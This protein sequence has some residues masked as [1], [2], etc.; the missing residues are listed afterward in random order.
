MSIFIEYEVTMFWVDRSM[1][2]ALELFQS[3]CQNSPN[4]EVSHSIA[5]NI[6][7]WIAVDYSKLLPQTG[8][9]VSG[10]QVLTT[11]SHL[12][13]MYW[14]FLFPF[15]FPLKIT[16]LIDPGMIPEISINYPTK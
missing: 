2:I 14:Y 16:K 5:V 15:F 3:F 7:E 11:S 12:Y 9:L 8:V 13:S 4:K 6:S 10:R 1:P